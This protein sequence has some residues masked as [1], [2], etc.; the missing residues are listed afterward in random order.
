MNE[1]VGVAGCVRALISLLEKEEELEKKKDQITKELTK[2]KQDSYQ[3]QVHLI[4]QLDPSPP[5]PGEEKRMSWTEQ[6]GKGG[7]VLLLT[8]KHSHPR[9]GVVNSFVVL[10]PVSL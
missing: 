7:R 10:R 2:I 9:D 6:G 5:S 1:K 4:R 8:S 3:C